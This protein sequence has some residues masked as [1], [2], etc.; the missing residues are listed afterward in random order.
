[1]EKNI[2]GIILT[3]LLAMLIIASGFF[4]NLTNIT[5]ASYL[6]IN[7]FPLLDNFLSPYFIGFLITISLALTTIIL[8]AHNFETKETMIFSLAG[9]LIG[10]L[11]ILALFVQLEFGIVL[12][13]GGLGIILSIKLYEKQEDNFSKSFKTG[14]SLTG[15][16]I[17]F[18]GIGVFLTIL[19]MTLP[20][21]NEYEQNFSKNILESFV[22]N[23]N[24]NLSSPL[25]GM[26]GNM[27]K[28][29]ISSIQTTSEYQKLQSKNDPDFLDFENKL[30]ELKILYASKEYQD[31][32]GKEVDNLASSE[33]ILPDLSSELPIVK[34]I[35]KF[36]W[37]IYAVLAFVSVLF[38]GEFIL[39]NISS[40]IFAIINKFT[41]PPNVDL[42]K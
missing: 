42:T 20:N 10:S 24:L 2:L 14:R 4:L 23:D 16:I 39:K 17:L 19:L 30:E 11:V 5:L 7:L 18:F 28:E 25:I 12:L 26:L 33:E 15:K 8:I 40:L 38:I 1:M 29:T 36:A 21:A 3:F 22:S 41:H 34:D 13:F 32:V 9:Y 35:A 6:T 31:L 37:L 27:Q